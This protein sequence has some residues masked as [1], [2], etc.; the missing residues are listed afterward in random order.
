VTEDWWIDSKF[1]G[2]RHRNELVDLFAAYLEAEGVREVG[3]IGILTYRG[4][5]DVQSAKLAERFRSRFSLA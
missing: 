2:Q 3:P 4:Q 1:R 5:Y